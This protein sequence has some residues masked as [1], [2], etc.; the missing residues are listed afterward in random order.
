MTFHQRHQSLVKSM[1]TSGKPGTAKYYYIR[2]Y[3][4]ELNLGSGYLAVPG[5]SVV[6]AI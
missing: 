3:L 2:Y 4:S 6:N 1:A 5:V